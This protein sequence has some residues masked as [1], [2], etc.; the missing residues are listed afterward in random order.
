VLGHRAEL[1]QGLLIKPAISTLLALAL[2]VSP[3]V[4]VGVLTWIYW[5]GVIAGSV[6]FVGALVIW[7]S[8]AT[9]RLE[10]RDCVISKRQFWVTRWSIEAS[11]ASIR[12]GLAGD[13]PIIPAIVLTDKRTRK[14]IGSILKSQFHKADLQALREVAAACARH[15]RE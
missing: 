7:L 6:L 9:I 14:V 10:V 3:G 4:V 12:D 8:V 13:I 15:A 11:N 1:H 2:P 5:D